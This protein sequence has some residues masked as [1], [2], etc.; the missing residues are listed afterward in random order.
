MGVIQIGKRAKV[1]NTSNSTKTSR[2]CYEYQTLIQ[3]SPPPLQCTVR[4]IAK[5]VPICC[6]FEWR[7]GGFTCTGPW[8]PPTCNS[9]FTS[10]YLWS[11]GLFTCKYETK[12][13]KSV[14]FGNCTSHL[15][16][17]WSSSKWQ[18]ATEG[19]WRERWSGGATFSQTNQFCTSK[20]IFL[21]SELVERSVLQGEKFIVCKSYE[22]APP[23]TFKLKSVIWRSVS[24]K[25]SQ[26]CI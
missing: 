14:E 19:G 5:P 1:C 22:C 10:L 11:V 20:D 24:Q 23:L 17:C 7:T 12:M 2:Q 9:R 13:S 4:H 16:S 8:L 25:S 26:N 3:P 15:L 21:L 6:I 18:V